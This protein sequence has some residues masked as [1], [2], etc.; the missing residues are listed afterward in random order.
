MTQEHL[1]GTMRKA[2]RLPNLDAGAKMGAIR[3]WDSLRHVGLILE[4]E[5]TYQVRIPP[6][7]FGSLTS[8]DAI[9]SYF[10]QQGRFTD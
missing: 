9:T 1:I 2:L 8:V 10:R 7:Q 5:K 4:L 6:D 3:G